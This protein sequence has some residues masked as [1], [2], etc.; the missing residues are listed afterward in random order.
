[1]QKVPK[2][3]EADQVLKTADDPKHLLA[4]IIHTIH[5]RYTSPFC[6]SIFRTAGK[7]SILSRIFMRKNPYD[8]VLEALTVFSLLQGNRRSYQVYKGQLSNTMPSKE[9]ETVSDVMNRINNVDSDA[10]A[11]RT[12]IYEE[13]LI[14]DYWDLGEL[15]LI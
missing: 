8:S 14:S 3:D 1:M 9:G 5:R 2:F 12:G 13:S 11:G 4:L 10:G 15:W 7:Q 6:R